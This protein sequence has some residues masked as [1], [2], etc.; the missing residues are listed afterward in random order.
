MAILPLLLG[1][2]SGICIATGIIFLFTGLRR[3]GRDRVHILFAIF[4]ISYAGANLTSV[5]EYKTTTLEGFLRMGDWTALFT[6]LTS[7]FPAMVRQRLYEGSAA[8]ISYY[9][10]SGLRFGDG[11]GYL[12]PHFGL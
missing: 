1:T 9:I 8:Y 7:S 5:L 6:V 2:S 3:P 4:A 12:T 10:D 11:C